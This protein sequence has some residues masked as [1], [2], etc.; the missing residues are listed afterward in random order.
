MKAS[1]WP[2]AAGP[3]AG[4]LWLFGAVAVV[5]KTVI[6]PMRPPWLPVELALARLR[7]TNVA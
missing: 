7:N 1:G 3:S 5:A 4:E 6:L 2:P